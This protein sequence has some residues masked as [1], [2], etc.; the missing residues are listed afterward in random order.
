V[1]LVATAVSRM[2]AVNRL[3]KLVNVHVAYAKEIG[4]MGEIF[5]SVEELRWRADADEFGASP[6]YHAAV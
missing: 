3:I 2:D 6:G 1:G 5:R 4:R